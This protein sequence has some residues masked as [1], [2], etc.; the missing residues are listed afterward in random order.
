M[1]FQGSKKRFTTSTIP[2]TDIVAEEPARVVLLGLCNDRTKWKKETGWGK[3]MQIKQGGKKRKPN[4]QGEWLGE[5]WPAERW[6]KKHGRQRHRFT[7][8]DWGDTAAHAYNRTRGGW[9]NPSAGL[10]NLHQ[11]SGHLSYLTIIPRSCPSWHCTDYLCLM[12]QAKWKHSQMTLQCIKALRPEQTGRW[13]DGPRK[14]TKGGTSL[15]NLV[16]GEV[17]AFEGMPVK[18]LWN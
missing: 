11:N 1:S 8:P 5:R 9:C 13:P 3:S 7:I 18:F 16:E 15:K 12:G 6:T 17:M 2:C 4:Q 10:G 14:S